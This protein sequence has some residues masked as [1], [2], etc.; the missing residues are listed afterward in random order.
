MENLI[1][2]IKILLIRE[3]G[4]K[5]DTEATKWL[6]ATNS[7]MDYDSLVRLHTSLDKS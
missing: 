7:H 1:S 3:Y 4:F 2:N 5:D 6:S